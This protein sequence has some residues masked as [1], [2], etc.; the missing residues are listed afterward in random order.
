[1]LKHIIVLLLLKSPLEQI[2]NKA[3]ALETQS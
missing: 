3:L 1:M 2:L